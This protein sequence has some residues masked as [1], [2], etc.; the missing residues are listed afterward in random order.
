MH[1]DAD[2]A[3]LVHFN[4]RERTAKAFENVFGHADRRFHVIGIKKPRGSA[5]VIVE[6]GW[7]S[8]E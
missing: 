6:V 5:L 2:L 4:G 8:G 3:M 7:R 1:R